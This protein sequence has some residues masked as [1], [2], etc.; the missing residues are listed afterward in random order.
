MA[1]RALT[2]DDSRTMRDMVWF[3]VDRADFEAG[4]AEDGV[5]P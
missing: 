4:V 5:L 1:K 3:T 2:V